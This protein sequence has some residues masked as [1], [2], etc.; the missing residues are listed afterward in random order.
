[1]AKSPL[2]GVNVILMGG[3]GA[4]KTTSI[5]TLIAKGITPFCIF[6]EPGQEVLGHIPSDQLH[7][8]YIPP[9]DQSW[10]SM[11]TLASTVNKISF[12][13]V[14]KMIDPQRTQYDQFVDLLTSLNNFRCDR[15]GESFGDCCK[16][17]TDRAVVVDSLTGAGIMA[18]GLV[19]GGKPVR[20]PGDWGMAMQFVE[21]L[22]T[23]LC[24]AT[25]CHFI[26][27]AHTE[28]ETDENSLQGGSRIMVAT[29]GKKLAPKMPRFF[30]DVVLAEK[31][32]PKY[33]WSTA[34]VGAE[35]KARNLPDATGLAPDF[36]PIIE[37]WKKQGGVITPDVV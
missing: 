2:P 27:M 10:E 25:Q 36:G 28:R 33:T 20:H 19:V 12:E 29:L 35:L 17:G 5:Q 30:S 15:T 22:F 3:V 8:H 18:M 6:T 32:G 34:T 26:L 11:I 16:W 21:N 31:T 37:S 14:T 13:A 1:M 24:T 23:K 4:G 9:A 7:W